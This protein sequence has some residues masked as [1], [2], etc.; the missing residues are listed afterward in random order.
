MLSGIA[1]HD[2]NAV[3]IPRR[4]CLRYALKTRHSFASINVAVHRGRAT[5]AF[6]RSIYIASRKHL[7]SFL[8]VTPNY[9]YMY[10]YSLYIF[11]LPD[12]G[13]TSPSYVMGPAYQHVHPCMGNAELFG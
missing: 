13:H 4:P 8:N 9:I 5:C 6:W 7:E 11:M 1:K 12:S 2:T 3:I 10:M